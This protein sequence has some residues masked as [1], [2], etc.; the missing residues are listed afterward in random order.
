MRGDN[1]KLNE[2]EL[3]LPYIPNK[4]FIKTEMDNQGL[5]IREAKRLDYQ[6]NWKEK[7]LL[8]RLETRCITAM[9]ERFMSKFENKLFWKVLVE[10][11]EDNKENSIINQSGVATVKVNYS[12]ND[13]KTL[14]NYKKKQKALELLLE[15]IRK[16]SQEYQWNMEEFTK[17][18]DM[19]KI[20]DYQNEWYWIK[21]LENSNKMYNADILCEHEVNFFRINLIVKNNLNQVVKKESIDEMPD[22]FAYAKHLGELKWV[23]SKEVVLFNKKGEKFISIYV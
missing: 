8:F 21:S 15:G 18:E 22:E 12:Y 1:V 20:D 2:F 7:R 9:F 13:F 11:V 23:S 5:T 17:V 4:E 10:V 3:D 14:D 6:K 19:I 16:I